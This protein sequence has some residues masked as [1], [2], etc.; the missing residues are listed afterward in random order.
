MIH[1]VGI[2]VPPSAQALDIFGPLDVFAEANR[3]LPPSSHYQSTV[4][5]IEPSSI[6]CSNGALLQ[7][8]RHY[9]EANEVFDLLLVAG[10]PLVPNQELSAD[11]NNWLRQAASRATR[12]GSICNGTFILARAGLL[13]GKTVTTHW[14]DAQ[15]LAELCPDVNVQPD[16]LYVCDKKLYTSA[17]VTAGID[18]ALFLVAID[19]G[20]DISLNTAKRLIVFTQ[21]AGGQSQFSPYLMPFLDTNSPMGAVQQ[22]V[23]ANLNGDLRVQTL[24]RVASMSPR[25]FTRVF[26]RETRV[27]PA[28]FVELARVDAA[29]RLLEQKSK[30]LKTIAVDCGF[31]DGQHMRDVFRRCL[32]VSP[33]QYRQSFGMLDA[34]HADIEQSPL[35]RTIKELEKKNVAS[36]GRTGNV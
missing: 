22:H 27:T 36:E 21:R 24:A 31:R 30:P 9:S 1:H 28:E 34:T 25:N 20:Q 14:N 4:I 35:S 26:S 16:R 5:G 10:G 29:R 33:Q 23:L 2:V 18:L 8:H 3:F 11:F 13:A 12:F 17:G 19:Q 7:P 15:A 32:G 6:R